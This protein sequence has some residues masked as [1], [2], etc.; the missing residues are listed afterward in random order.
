MGLDPGTPVSRPEPKADA[1]PLSP[2]EAP[3]AFL[4]GEGALKATTNEEQ[5][6]P[7]SLVLRMSLM[8]SGDGG[9]GR[10]AEPEKDLKAGGG[11]RMESLCGPWSLY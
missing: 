6:Q 11:S 5:K 4:F 2:P 10:E 1:Q 9:W 8:T 7:S 3:P